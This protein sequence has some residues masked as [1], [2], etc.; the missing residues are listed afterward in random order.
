MCV[1]RPLGRARRSRRVKDHERLPGLGRD[2]VLHGR[3]RPGI[4][5]KQHVARVA[6][7]GRAGKRWPLHVDPA[8][9]ADRFA[10]CHQQAR[11]AVAEP[12]PNGLGPESRV[13]RHRD[14]AQPGTGQQKADCLDPVRHQ[15]R[16][17]VPPAHPLRGEKPRQLPDEG[18]RFRVTQPPGIAVLA[19]G[20]KGR[21]VGLSRGPCEDRHTGVEDGPREPAGERR[22][23]GQVNI[24][25][26]GEIDPAFRHRPAPI[27]GRASQCEVQQRVI[28]G[29]V[30]PGDQRRQPGVLERPGI[31][32]PGRCRLSHGRACGTGCRPA[33]ASRQRRHVPRPLRAR[34]SR[35]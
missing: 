22:P 33:H 1:H 32:T 18:K 5:E 26:E 34:R 27:V 14:C 15:Q 30:Q 35:V 10:H 4:L 13:E 9:R 3:G 28:R 21:P 2:R 24:F 23:A 12:L 29:Q 25:G 31:R 8:S 6:Q 7:L 17:A 20:D 16:D 19:F 11:P